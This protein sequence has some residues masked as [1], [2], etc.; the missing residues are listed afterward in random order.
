MSS[1]ESQIRAE[2]VQK[3]L[4]AHERS[5]A[6]G[7]AGPW[8]RDVILPVDGK[9]FP[10]A[11]ASDGREKLDALC[12]AILHL[13]QVKLCRVTYEKGG[14]GDALPKQV[15]LGPEEL[16]AAYL[17]AI[18]HGFLPLANAFDLVRS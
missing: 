1:S 4:E 9:T 5:S 18:S 15:R 2:I 16:S 13:E 6:F 14:G 12:R 10:D 8:P 7:K 3:L 11:F 17:A